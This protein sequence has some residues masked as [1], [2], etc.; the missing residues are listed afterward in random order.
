MI[1]MDW[2]LRSAAPG[3]SISR[4]RGGESSDALRDRTVV[5][6]LGNRLRQ[7]DFVFGRGRCLTRTQ[8]C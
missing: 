5:R 4:D 7:R 2:R 8:R 6:L 3:D 1:V